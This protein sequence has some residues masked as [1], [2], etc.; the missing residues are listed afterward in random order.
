MKTIRTRYHNTWCHGCHGWKWIMINIYAGYIWYI[1]HEGLHCTH[2][3]S[4]SLCVILLKWRKPHMRRKLRFPIYENVLN[5]GILSI[6]L[7]AIYSDSPGP[8][9]ILLGTVEWLDINTHRRSRFMFL[10]CDNNVSELYVP[11]C[12]YGS[13]LK[14]VESKLNV[15]LYL[16]FNIV[17]L[18]PTD[19]TVFHRWCT[20]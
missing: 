9:C 20:K 16:C 12:M 15:V 13:K 19:I 11:T 4:H 1:V 7:S 18:W 17:H 10:Y 2:I 6:I 5:Y 14:W 3:C 8:L